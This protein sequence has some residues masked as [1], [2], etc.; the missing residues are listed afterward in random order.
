MIILFRLSQF[1]LPLLNGDIHLC[2]LLCI[3]TTTRFLRFIW[4]QL[5]V[6]LSNYMI[7]FWITNTWSLFTMII[8]Q[9]DFLM[10]TLPTTCVNDTG[11]A[12]DPSGLS[13]FIIHNVG[14]TFYQ[15]TQVT[16]NRTYSTM[17]CKFA[18]LTFFARRLFPSSISRLTGIKS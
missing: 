11:L 4:P 3:E 13:Y 15:V 9:W 8:M 10:L 16:H 14:V 2:L 12:P 17:A 1:H 6:P 7:L 5:P 18:T